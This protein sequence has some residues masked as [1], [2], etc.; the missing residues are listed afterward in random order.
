[1]VAENVP[2]ALEVNDMIH[3]MQQATPA[4]KLCAV[5]PCVLVTVGRLGFRVYA[6]G[7]G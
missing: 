2:D 3:D 4:T 1:M 5:L 6:Q 7:L